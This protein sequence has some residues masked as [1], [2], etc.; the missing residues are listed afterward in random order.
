MV[1][2]CC[3]PL[4]PPSSHWTWR[5]TCFWSIPTLQP[6]FVFVDFL[7]CYEED[8]SGSSQPLCLFLPTPYHFST[9]PGPPDGMVCL[10]WALRPSQIVEEREPSIISTYLVGKY[11][12]LSSFWGKKKKKLTHIPNPIVKFKPKHYSFLS[13]YHLCFIQQ[14]GRR[15]CPW[16]A[17][18]Q[19]F[20]TAPVRRSC[21]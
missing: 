7:H 5:S 13:V 18:S 16:W 11:R 1:F 10:P 9:L 2:G 21:L 20:T 4:G 14:F 12:S 6:V 15:C 17:G 3:L 8:Y 19:M